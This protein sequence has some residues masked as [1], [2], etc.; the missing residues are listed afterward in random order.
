MTI[1]EYNVVEKWGVPFSSQEMNKYGNDGWE[2]VTV[3]GA[4]ETLKGSL[5]EALRYF[6]FKRLKKD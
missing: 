3:I 2:L 6:V 5:S 4:Y 1:W